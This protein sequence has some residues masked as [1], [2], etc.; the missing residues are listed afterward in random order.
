MFDVVKERHQTVDLTGIT[1]A[2][3]D[4][5]FYRAQLASSRHS[6]PAAVR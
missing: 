2:G 3:Y 1:K 5:S 6:L 4:F